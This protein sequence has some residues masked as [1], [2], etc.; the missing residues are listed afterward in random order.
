MLQPDR[1]WANLCRALGCEELAGDER[2][3]DLDRRGEHS[4]ELIALFDKIFIT[5]TRDEIEKAFQQEGNII[6][7]LVKDISDVVKDPQAVANDYIVDF[8]HPVLGN[9]KL[10]NYPVDFSKTPATMRLPAPEFGQHTEEVLTELLGYTW[11]QISE[12][13]EEEVI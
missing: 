7:E 1:H 9:V 6:Y 3:R 4:A 12:L 13:K 2:F 10:L 8:A 5:K 11:D